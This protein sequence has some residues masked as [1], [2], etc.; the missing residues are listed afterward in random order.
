MNDFFL[1]ASAVVSF[2]ITAKKT[3]RHTI[4]KNLDQ[5]L[6]NHSE[7]L[8]AKKLLLDTS[9]A[10]YCMYVPC[11]NKEINMTKITMAGELK[12]AYEITAKK[13]ARYRMCSFILSQSVHTII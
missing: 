10:N 12:R 1:F 6:E 11:R 8:R 3:A 7:W 5:K 2:L 4:C 9:K 13:T